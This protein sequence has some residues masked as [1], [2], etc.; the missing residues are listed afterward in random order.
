MLLAGL[1]ACRSTSERAEAHY[2]SRPTGAGQFELH[3]RRAVVRHHRGR[4]R[5]ADRQ[6]DIVVTVRPGALLHHASER[7]RARPVV[8]TSS[9]E[10]TRVPSYL[11]VMSNRPVYELG[12]PDSGATG[13]VLPTMFAQRSATISPT[14]RRTIRFAPPSCGQGSRGAPSPIQRRDL[15]HATL[16]RATVQI[17]G[18]ALT[19]DYEVETLLISNGTVLAKQQTAFEV[20]KTASRLRR[21]RIATARGLLRLVPRSWRSSVFHRLA[22]VQALTARGQHRQQLQPA[23]SALPRGDIFQKKYAFGRTC[24]VAQVT[25]AMRKRKLSRRIAVIVMRFDREGEQPAGRKLVRHRRA[26]WRQVRQIDEHI[27]G[28]NEIEG[29]G[30]RRQKIGEIR[31][32]QAVITCLRRATPPCSPKDRRRLQFP[33]R[34]ASPIRPV[35]QPRSSARLKRRSPAVRVPRDKRRAAVVQRRPAAVEPAGILVNSGAHRP[36][37]SRARWCA[38][39]ALSRASRSPAPTASGRFKRPAEGRDRRFVFPGKLVGFAQQEPAGDS[40]DPGPASS[41]NSMAARTSPRSIAAPIHGAGRGPIAGRE[42]GRKQAHSSPLRQAPT[43]RAGTSG[44]GLRLS[45]PKVLRS[46][47]L[48]HLPMLNAGEA[49]GGKDVR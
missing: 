29:F 26:N 24:R 8:N 20:V 2:W 35:P 12:Q 39:R 44:Q 49:D 27:R 14:S 15:R 3:R 46:S 19:G 45:A 17:L 36:A 6:Y 41:S 37:T 11:A 1:A 40:R 43:S 22:S 13:S 9:R 34:T 18:N 31:H 10:F 47:R 33:R 4:R 21:R 23:G 30:F 16:F 25:P 28:Q 32:R 48:P 5:R 42:K 38:L 7:A